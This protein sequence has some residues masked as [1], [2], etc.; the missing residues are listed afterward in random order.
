MHDDCVQICDVVWK[1]V[2]AIKAT[3]RYC[4][5]ADVMTCTVDKDQLKL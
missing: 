1:M 4:F 5:L 2:E 3:W